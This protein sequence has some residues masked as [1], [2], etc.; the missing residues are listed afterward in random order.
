LAYRTAAIIRAIEDSFGIRVSEDDIRESRTLGEL[1]EYFRRRIGDSSRA[2]LETA[3][4]S[5]RLRLGL[6]ESFGIARD[7]ITN[8]T[9]LDTLFPRAGRLEK[10]I[11][12]EDAA[13]LTL[14]SL[15]HPRWLAIGSLAACLLA[16]GVGI[17]IFWHGW[18]TDQRLFGLIV[19]PFWPFMLWWM[20][21]YFTRGLARSFP[22][23]CQTFGDLVRLTARINPVEPLGD[24]A[25]ADAQDEDFIWKSLQALIAVETGR[26][27]EEIHPHTQVSE[28]I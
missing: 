1:G 20:A 24:A 2:Q 17:G 18:S 26:Q 8:D 15:T 21:L 22:H 11:A 10:W 23:D 13:Q 7:T 4:I 6:R 19:A 14:P 16:M 27:I 9:Q 28:V 12:L 25:G 5:Y 3:A